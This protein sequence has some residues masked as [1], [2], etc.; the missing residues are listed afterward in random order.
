MAGLTPNSKNINRTKAGI[1]AHATAATSPEYTYWLPE[2][3]KI[4]DALA[5]ER[6]IKAKEEE[7]LP[8][9]TGADDAQYEQYLLRAVFYNMSAQTLAGMVGQMFRRPPVIRDL[10]TPGRI[11]TKRETGDS[12][13]VSEGKRLAPMLARFTKDGASHIAFAKTAAAEQLSMGRF[14][15]LVDVPDNGEPSPR[16]Y[17][18]GY[19]AENILD[20]KIEEVD[21]YYALTRV[22]LRE[23]RREDGGLSSDN[24]HLDPAANKALARRRRRGKPVT[25]QLSYGGR[26]YT[27]YY[28]E[29]ALEVQPDGTR[30]Y[31]QNIYKGDPTGVAESTVYPKVRGNELPFIPAVFFGAHSNTPDVEKPPLLDIVDLNIKHYRTYAELEYGRFYTALPTYYTHTGQGHEDTDAY[32]IGPGTV[33]ECPEGANPPGIIEFKGEGLKTLERA[34]QEKEQQI[35]A[36]GGRMMPG[37]SRS[38]SESNQQA[39]M[40]EANEQSLL[41]NVVSALED[42]MT[43]LLRYWLMF[44]DVPLSMSVP[45]RYEVDTTFLSTAAD[46]RTIR[47]LQQLYEGG[48]I[49][50]EALYEALL[51]NGVLPQ[52]MTL[53]DFE[54]RMSDSGSFLGQP[55]AEAMRRGYANRAQELEQQHLAREDYFRSWELELAERARE[56][57]EEKVKFAQQFGV[58]QVTGARELGDVEQAEPNKK[59]QRQLRLQEKQAD[60]AAKQQQAAQQQAARQPAASTPPNPPRNR[61]GT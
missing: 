61:R 41:L 33:W 29:L 45:V 59:T 27:V 28:R 36:I 48:I 30:K 49:P 16:P 9:M 13:V 38:I 56:L 43:M 34:L 8:R 26:T 32:H 37:A 20:W 55:D 46:A 60:L 19:T 42:G 2:W 11:V 10:P 24:K 44:V 22:L 58:N 39:T 4:R 6:A 1:L 53:E 15:A 40:R 5:G 12:T 47:A 14:L 17:A 3:V 18:V 57:E 51:K 35:A 50:V 23:Y 21:G 7:Y 31:C 54:T 52:T 25:N